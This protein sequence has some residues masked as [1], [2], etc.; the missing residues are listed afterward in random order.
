MIFL[1]FLFL[2]FIILSEAVNSAEAAVALIFLVT[3]SFILNI[4]NETLKSSVTEELESLK[5]GYISF[6]SLEKDFLSSLLK[7]NQSFLAKFN[8]IVYNLFIIFISTLSLIFNTSFYSTNA[9]LPSFKQFFIFSLISKINNLF[10][11]RS[12][13]KKSSRLKINV[14]QVLSN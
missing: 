6:L 12:L 5:N 3:F 8:S 13:S 2:C 10:N 9:S 4:V 1:I 7:T 14:L 11:L